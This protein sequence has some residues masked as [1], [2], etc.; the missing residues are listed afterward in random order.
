MPV[1]EREKEHEWVKW[2][3]PVIP[4]LGRQKQD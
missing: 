4:K 1:L 2:N 3:T